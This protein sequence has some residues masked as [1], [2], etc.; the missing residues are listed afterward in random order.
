MKARHLALLVLLMPVRSFADLLPDNPFT[1]NAAGTTS[2]AFLKNAPSARYQALGSAGAALDATDAVFYNPAGLTTSA[3]T[4]TTAGHSVSFSYG[5]MYE[6]LKKTALAYTMPLK[7]GYFSAG[8][9][10]FS[11]GDQE[12]YNTTGD[13]TGT[14]G[15]HDMALSGAYA[16][17]FTIN[18]R[19]VDIGAA[20]KYIRSTIA[21]E[22]AAAMAA[23]GG[24]ILRQEQGSTSRIEDFGIYFRNLGTPMKIGTASEPLPL[25]LAAGLRSREFYGARVLADLK[26]PVDNSPYFC[27]GAEWA[28]FYDQ[29]G[30]FDPI[31]R[32]GF[33]SQRNNNFD[34]A[35]A[36]SAGAGLGFERLVFDYAWVPMGD[37]GSTHKFTLSWMF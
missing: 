2:A 35:S 33:N 37:L 6:T 12:G 32:L 10:Y 19:T 36:L 16:R 17:R 30:G 29:R 21:E 13:Y 1:D 5:T 8:L 31:L 18:G 25:E 26:M 34:F 15:A 7:G 28:V 23:D 24:M 27:L 22:S 11:Q 9:L 14:F 20:L 3:S 4:I